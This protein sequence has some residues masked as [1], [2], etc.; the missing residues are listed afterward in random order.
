MQ[1]GMKAKEW[2]LA[3]SGSCLLTVA[4]LTPAQVSA[5]ALR[6]GEE[7][8]EVDRVQVEVTLNE[9]T[10]MAV[11]L[12]PD[13]SQL[14]LS[15]QGVLWSLPIEGGEAIP[16]TSPE[17]E[18]YEPV[19]SP[20]GNLVTFYSYFD[21]AFTVWTMSP[22]GSN[23]MKLTEGVGDARYP[24]FSPDGLSVIYSSDEE[25]GYSV[26]SIDLTS[27]DR[28]KLVDAE[29]TGYE[30]PTGPYFSGS[31]NAVYPVLSPDGSTLAFVVDGEQDQLML[32][33]LGVDNEVSSLYT[34]S[35]LGAPL[36]SPEGDALYV[37][38][39]DE[40]DAHLTRVP[41]DGAGVEALV[42]SGDVF[43]FRPSL[44][45]E[46]TLYYT[47]N[48]A[49]QTLSA[50]GGKTATV[51]FSA[52][53]MLDRTAYKR[54]AY[55]FADRS[56]M[57]ALGIIDPTLSPD[58]S[59]VVFAALGDLWLTDLVSN[60]SQRL[61]DDRY[62]DLSPSWSPDGSRIAFASDR[63]GKSDI[64]I[65]EVSSGALTRLTD[66]ATAANAPAWSPDG[67]Q[68]AYLVDFGQSVF[69]SAAVV[70]K[71][72]ASGQETILSDGIF[73]PSAPVWSPDGSVLAIYHRKPM[74]SRFREGHNAINLL[75]VSGAG[76]KRWVS[77][78]EDM[79]LGRRQFIRPAWSVDS[80]MVYRFDGGLWKATLTPDGEIGP[81]VK[82]AT[83]GE[84]PSWSA[85]GSKLIYMDGASIKL[86]DAARETTEIL[87]IKPQWTRDLPDDI[88]T[89]R[90]GRLFDGTGEDYQDNVDI[91][92]E[93]GVITSVKP[94]GTQAPLGRFIDASAQVV[95]PGLIEGH[96]HQSTSQGVALGE[97]YLSYGIT[98]VR[99]TGGDPYYA[100]E[101]REAEASGRRPGPRVF[102]GGP[103]NEGGRV[104]YGVSETV[105]TP[106]QAENSMRLSTELEL[107]LY[108]SYVRQDYTTQK[109]VIELAHE[110][111]I[112]VSSHELFPAVAN[113][114]DQIEHF[115]A[116]SR[117][118][119]SLVV[120]RLG[121]SYQDVISLVSKSGM[122]VTPTLALN[123]RGGTQDITGR[124]ETLKKI[125]D[126]GGRIIAGTDSPF[127]P[128]AESLHTEIEIYVKAGLTPAQA[129]RTATSASA[130]ALGAGDQLGQLVPGFMADLVVLDGDPLLTITDTRKVNTVIKSGVV[131]W[132]NKTM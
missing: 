116:T 35:I 70:V 42:S 132:S 64:W 120:S 76:E 72:L 33:K 96:T 106:Q 2:I 105:G 55:D 86:Y 6:L 107:D 65:M 41:V 16:L 91:V 118:G 13:A 50:D 100:V 49:I 126:A 45:P 83:A 117:R 68:I 28:E 24:S 122:V 18:A 95:I 23:L 77:P 75:P 38:G 47:A 97:L 124:A 10:N 62:V 21:N 25:G 102:T 51:P 84:N 109:R 127:I 22:D 130:A 110:S 59:M 67:S 7:R 98:S 15:V 79:S 119:F 94:A 90:A 8:V 112:P 71:N 123:S 104:S 14:I 78:V 34:S 99:E 52:S 53:V 61:T 121:N 11:A 80:E 57:P 125:V 82:I 115:G 54:R 56:P 32:R 128:H 108:K 4:I 89:V 12:S 113:G 17:M 48:G 27:G 37:V 92:I 19:W 30:H 101:R 58:A 85:D 44:D 114:V 111:G 46:G 39:I 73:G 40:G 3:L 131:V 66:S 29:E 103:L 5:Q 43:P 60:E 31:G 93:G 69:I 20:L 74:N 81:S 88:L 9:G 63:E 129:L 87:D 36:W 26:W 1:S